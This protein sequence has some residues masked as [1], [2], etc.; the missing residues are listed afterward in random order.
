MMINKK[1][2]NML[3]IFKK[4]LIKH[5]NNKINILVKGN[6]YNI[7]IDIV[8]FYKHQKELKTI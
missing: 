7:Y 2:M 3:I 8:Q 6:I 1:Q 4:L 5:V